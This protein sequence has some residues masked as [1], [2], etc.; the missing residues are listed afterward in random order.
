MPKKIGG[1]IICATLSSAA[2]A[3]ILGNIDLDT[4]NDDYDYTMTKFATNLSIPS[5]YDCDES[6]SNLFNK[7]GD[8]DESYCKVETT[9]GLK[10]YCFGLSYTGASV[11]AN[12]PE[13]A[14]IYCNDPSEYAV[15]E[16][17][18]AAQGQKFYGCAKYFPGSNCY[19][20]PTYT[21]QPTNPSDYTEIFP[22]HA[23]MSYTT[24]P[25]E[26]TMYSRARPNIYGNCEYPERG[27]FQ[28]CYCAYE[29][30]Y[31]I[32]GNTEPDDSGKI[33]IRCGKCPNNANCN[34]GTDTFSCKAGYYRPSLRASSC[35]NC[36]SASSNIID[37]C[38]TQPTSPGGSTSI[39]QCYLPTSTMCKD[40]YG[41]FS[42][43]N[44][45]C[46]YSN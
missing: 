20:G 1:L 46:N 35:Y 34:G 5:K 22:N 44:G 26:C 11:E 36:P 29:E 30:S 23:S 32:S 9:D 8:T 4:Y 41:T 18:G 43:V 24:K 38:D 45:N 37:F 25:L 39:T 13:C 15:W 33:T 14:N 3:V 28:E 21:D 31:Y 27:P 19:S 40:I 16:R 7:Y 10:F 2:N 42:I 6:F 17:T 12:L